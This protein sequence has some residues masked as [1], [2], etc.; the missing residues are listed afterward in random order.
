M[1]LAVQQGFDVKVVPLPPGIDPADDP[2]GFEARLAAAEAYLA[3]RVRIEIDRADDRESAF[4]AVKALLEAAPDSPE[5]QD[6]WRYAND[7]LGISVQLRAGA[8]SARAAEPASRRVLDASAKL[9]R[10]ALAG[11]LAHDRLKPLLAELTEDHFYDPMH[12]RLR[13]HIVAG[14]P[15]DA[16]G[17]GL[18]AELDARAVLE[19]ID[20]ATGEELIWRLRER[21]LRRE[22]QHSDP[23]RTKELQQA[24]Q[25]L[26]ERVATLS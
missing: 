17:V 25:R 22:L 11:V 23:T 5:R 8:V 2:T 18:L 12:R 15:L 10:N 16:E 13:A 21:E 19:G 9:E 4:R 26:L 14:A 6:A 20:D 1:A 24:L 7:K 3:Y